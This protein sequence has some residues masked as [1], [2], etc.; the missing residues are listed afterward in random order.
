MEVRKM[1]KVF[2]LSM[3]ALVAL[4]SLFTLASP[5][6]THPVTKSIINNKTINLFTVYLLCLL[7]IVVYQYAA[8][9]SMTLTES[10]QYLQNNHYRQP[11]GSYLQKRG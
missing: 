8:E 7:L 10:L 2:K 1:K 5:A 9:R 3:I 11:M 4:F 6:D